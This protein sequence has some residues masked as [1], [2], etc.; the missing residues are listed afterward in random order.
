MP[1]VHKKAMA[2]CRSGEFGWSVYDGFAE[3]L[4]VTESQEE[5]AEAGLLC[6][7]CGRPMRLRWL[8][9]PNGRQ[10]IAIHDTG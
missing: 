3:R 9:L 2:T 10:A 1:A 5:S 7:H 6:P 4:T 8:V